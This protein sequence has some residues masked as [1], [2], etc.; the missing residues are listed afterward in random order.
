MNWQRGWNRTRVEDLD[1]LYQLAGKLGVR[2]TD[3]ND[4]VLSRSV[5][6][7]TRRAR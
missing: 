3:H 1:Q 5:D 4:R 2:A 6:T 7:D